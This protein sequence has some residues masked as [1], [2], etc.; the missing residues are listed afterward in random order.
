MRQRLLASLACLMRQL[1][2]SGL[3]EDSHCQEHN[4]RSVEVSQGRH[5]VEL[6]RGHRGVAPKYLIALLMM[7]DRHWV[8]LYF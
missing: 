4:R 2:A 8:L 3:E 1:Y 6:D 5:F 7:W